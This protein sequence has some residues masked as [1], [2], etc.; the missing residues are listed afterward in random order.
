MK[1]TKHLLA[2][3]FS[4]GFIVIV[5]ASSLGL[6]FAV[7][8]HTPQYNEGYNAACT[9]AKHR[10]QIWDNEGFIWDGFAQKYPKFLSHDWIQ[11]YR[12]GAFCTHQHTLQY[13]SGFTAGCHDKKTCLLQ[14]PG[15]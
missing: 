1:K 3:A 9:D 12:D 2:L 10:I 5:L 4:I 6:A 15:G 13:D 11:G 14:R 7:V 8:I